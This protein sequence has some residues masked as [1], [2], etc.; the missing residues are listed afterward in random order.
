[1]FRKLPKA[2]SQ[3]AEFKPSFNEDVIEKG[4]TA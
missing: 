2:E 1:M 4:E 3:T